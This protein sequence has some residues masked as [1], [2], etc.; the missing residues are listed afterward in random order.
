MK[1][2]GNNLYHQEMRIIVVVR[3][4]KCILYLVQDTVI[5]PL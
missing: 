5:S 4:F 2:N 1:W 3:F